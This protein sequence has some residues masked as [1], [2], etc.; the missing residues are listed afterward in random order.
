MCLLN[1]LKS[2]LKCLNTRVKMHPSYF[3][4]IYLELQSL[5]K[6]FSNYKK[7]MQLK[8]TGNS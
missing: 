7:S 6:K 5:N 8:N 1:E 4:T 3:A 2:F